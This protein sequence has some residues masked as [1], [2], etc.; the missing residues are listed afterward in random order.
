MTRSDAAVVVLVVVVLAGR[1]RAR[2]G[3]RAAPAAMMRSMVDEPP[4]EATGT[5][6][7]TESDWTELARIDPIAAAGD[8]SR[9]A[10]LRHWCAEGL[11]LVAEDPPEAHPGRASGPLGYCVLEYTFFEQG[12]VTMLM[13]AP[14]ARRRGV[15]TRLLAAADAWCT[16][17]KLFTSSNLSNQPMRRL[18]RTTGWRPVGLVQGLDEGDP[19]L[20]YLSPGSPP[21]PTGMADETLAGVGEVVPLDES[22]EVNTAA[23]GS[24]LPLEDPDGQRREDGGDGQGPGQ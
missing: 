3:R 5:R 16:T 4:D 19:E 9:R 12:F 1:D 18:L 13:V 10:Q 11:A 24:Q 7:A 6:R 15:G 8:D 23:A 2:G 20:F 22:A 14:H 21:P 17:P